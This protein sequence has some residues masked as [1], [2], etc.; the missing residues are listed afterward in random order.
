MTMVCNHNT[1]RWTTLQHDVSAAGEILSG[2]KNCI[3]VSRIA[4]KEASVG[5][6][7][8]D[9]ISIGCVMQVVFAST[10]P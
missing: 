2:L 6:G 9:T 1:F 7:D 4:H 3:E 5:A 8:N 10:L